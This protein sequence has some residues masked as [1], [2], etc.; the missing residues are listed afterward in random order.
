MLDSALFG[1]GGV[2]FGPIQGLS[3]PGLAA[4]GILQ[5]VE[6]RLAPVGNSVGRVDCRALSP[7]FS[8]MTGP[9]MPG[10]RGVPRGRGEGAG[11]VEQTDLRVLGELRDLRVQT[12]H[13]ART[14]GAKAGPSRGPSTHIAIGAVEFGRWR[15]RALSGGA[16]GHVT[17][18]L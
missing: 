1:P 3:E 2:V 6:F 9:L 14:G 8:M 11:P 18:I 16:H 10:G 13:S 4:A 15:E 7:A 17:E 5:A 12:G